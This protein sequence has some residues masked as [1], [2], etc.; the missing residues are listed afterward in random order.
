MDVLG[1]TQSQK[2]FYFDKVPIRAEIV[3]QVHPRREVYRL[4]L[5]R[6]QDLHGLPIV[7]I[8]KKIKNEWED[9]F[10]QEI[11]AYEELKSLQGLVI[12]TFFGQGTFDDCPVL[13]LSE[14]AGRTLLDVSRRASDIST[15][16]LR[17]Q[18]EKAMKA[19]HSYGAEYLN[20]RLDDFFLCDTGAIMV[21]DLE[22]VEF[23][24]ALEDWKDSVNY[25]GVGFLL[26]LFNDIREWKSRPSPGDFQLAESNTLRDSAY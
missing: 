17:Y 10:Q 14:V 22:Q 7:V 2:T 13:I 9:E 11:K 25:G 15:D 26:Y 1:K 24:L 3:E 8:L 21:V 18:L 6:N 4:K 12:P 20:Q 23:P 19:L 16:E 5:E